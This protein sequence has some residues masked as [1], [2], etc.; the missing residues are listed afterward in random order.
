MEKEILEKIGLTKTESIIYLSLLQLGTSKTGN[1]IKHAKINSGRIYET[2]ESLKEKGLISESIIN[3]VKHFTASSPERILDFIKRKKDSLKDEEE[4]IKSSL[5]ELN[6]LKSVGL[7]STNVFIYSGMEGIKT[8]AYE[9]LNDLKG[10]EE[11]LCMGVTSKKDSKFNNFW[12][13]FGLDRAKKKVHTKFL[14]S[15]DSEFIAENSQKNLT[16]SRILGEITPTTV[17]IFGED[18]VLILDYTGEPSCILIYDRPTATSFRNFFYQLWKIAEKK[19]KKEENSQPQENHEIE[20]LVVNILIKKKLSIAIAESCTGGLLSATIVNFPGIGQVFKEGIITYS[21]EA[22]IKRAHVKKETLDMYGAVSPEVAMEMA[23]GIA[24]ENNSQ[25]GISITG[26]ASKGLVPVSKKE[27]KPIGLVYIGLSIN[28]ETYY[29]TIH[30]Y[31]DRQEIRKKVVER[32]LEF[33]RSELDK[34]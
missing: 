22:K 5:E 3:N 23:E 11:I 13:K 30:L 26:V 31:G 4:I 16:E 7:S 14:Y 15:E 21:N 24:K 27:E 10:G 34:M 17:D 20:K 12:L 6:S 19:N 25:I 1:I 32:A 18:K 33:L 28:K 9:A 8:A 2:L 29:R